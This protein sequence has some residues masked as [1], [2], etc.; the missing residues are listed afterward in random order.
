MSIA[1]DSLHLNRP[2]PGGRSYGRPRI[3]AQRR[4]DVKLAIPELPAPDSITLEKVG[5]FLELDLRRVSVWLG[6]WKFVI[7]AL[8]VLGGV[9]GAAYGILSKP[10]YTVT[11]DILIDPTGLQ[12]LG[13]GTSAASQQL[14][15][16]ALLAASSKLRVMTSGNVLNRVIGD[17]ELTGDPEFVGPGNDAIDPGAAALAALRKAIKISADEKSFVASMAVT[18][19]T[20]DKSI[21][22]SNAIF[23]AFQDELAKADAQGADRIVD[24]IDAKLEELK[25]AA[26]TADA[27]I[28]AYKRRNGLQSSAGELTSTLILND[29]NTRMATAQGALIAA[30]SS[31]EQ[32]RSGG[33][34]TTEPGQT[35]A[36]DTLRGQLAVAQ[37]QLLGQSQVLGARH[38]TI[39]KLRTEVEALTAQVAAE[40]TRMI[41]AARTRLDEAAANVAALNA[42]VDTQK[43]SVFTDNQA[44]VQLRDLERDAKTSAALYEAFLGRSQQLAQ[45][46][47]LDTTNVRVISTAMPP[48][49]RSWPPRTVLMVLLGAAA[50]LLAGLVIAFGLGLAGDLRRPRRQQA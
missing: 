44:L 4:P 49:A 22:I 2:E 23:I 20:V 17:L 41:A 42:K 31:Y 30:Q 27:A 12:V 28:E 8:I 24:G 40:T 16:T 37:Q 25:T 46:G 26:S 45:S 14:P 6:R 5:D 21:L 3:T 19:D 13:D 1:S 18:T 33:T 7:L 32:L 29:L 39:V 47:T 50:G 48:V 34:G 36:L 9:G 15:D 11:A 43:S 10:S 38:P 35:T